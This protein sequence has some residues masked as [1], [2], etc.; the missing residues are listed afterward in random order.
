MIANSAS[1]EIVPSDI[2]HTFVPFWALMHM[3]EGFTL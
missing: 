3:F 1:P 2:M